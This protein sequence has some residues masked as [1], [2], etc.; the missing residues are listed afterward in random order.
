MRNRY[1]HEREEKHGLRDKILFGV[2]IV[3]LSG[4]VAQYFGACNP[5]RQ[6]ADSHAVTSGNMVY[7]DFDGDGDVDSA[8]RS[9]SG[10]LNEIKYDNNG[11]PYIVQ[12]PTA[13]EVDPTKPYHAQ[14]EAAL[15]RR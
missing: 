10:V 13:F 2:A 5:A 12:R 7:A 8:V 15:G 11:N 6:K 14:R 3:G 1:I 4:V 9:K